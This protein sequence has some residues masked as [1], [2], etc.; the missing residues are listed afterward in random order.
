MNGE[1][2]GSPVWLNLAGIAL[3]EPIV[4]S[5]VL[6]ALLAAGS[7]WIGRR[8]VARRGRLQ[9]A[10]EA[11]VTVMSDAVREVVPA[12]DVPRVLPFVG[13]LW[14][15]ILAANLIGLVPGLSSP[16]RDLSVTAALATLV[17]SAVHVYGI[18]AAG[19]RAYLRHYL[20][21]SPLLLPFHLISELTR[22]LALAVRLFGN[23]MSLEMAALLVLLVAGFLVPVPLLLLHVVEALVQA[24]IFG[25]LALIYIGSALEA[26]GPIE[27]SAA[28]VPDSSSIVE[29]AR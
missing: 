25:M 14:L 27:Q 13:T 18:R 21:P 10:A 28:E 4:L 17:F 9:V 20:Q 11:V 1:G 5:F 23:M 6:T 12:A 2:L 22:T 8:L 29:K 15:F 26:R 3:G 19:W 16:T 7:Y 24:Y